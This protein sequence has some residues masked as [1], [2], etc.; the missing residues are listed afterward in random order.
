MDYL[1]CV[2]L[3]TPEKTVRLIF[4][5]RFWFEHI[6]FANLIKVQSYSQFLVYQLFRLAM[7]SLV[8][9]LR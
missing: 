1:I 6:A 8:L 3:K 4:S 5:E 9:Q 2:Y 7:S